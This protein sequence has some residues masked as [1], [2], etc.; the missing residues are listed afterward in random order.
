MTVLVSPP[1][2]RHA[3]SPS[4]TNHIPFELQSLSAKQHER[5]LYANKLARARQTFCICSCLKDHCKL[6]REA[7][8]VARG[9]FLFLSLVLIVV[10]RVR[11]FQETGFFLDSLSAAVSAHRVMPANSSIYLLVS[12]NAQRHMCFI[13]RGRMDYMAQ[14]KV[15]HLPR[16]AGVP[17]E[18]AHISSQIFILPFTHE[19]YEDQSGIYYHGD[20]NWFNS[21]FQPLDGENKEENE[22][23]EVSKDQT[24]DAEFCSDF[25]ILVGG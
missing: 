17:M 20:R 1:A 22:E 9:T 18:M 4:Q 24:Y 10:H 8:E 5:R 21:D 3:L 6:H 14:W 13:T 15:F 25:V 2:A 19:S 16:L 23:E 7:A 11:F 12:K